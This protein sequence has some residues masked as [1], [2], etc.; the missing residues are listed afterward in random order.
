MT[1][2]SQSCTQPSEK[3]V[4]VLDFIAPPLL[5][6]SEHGVNGRHRSIRQNYL[7]KAP[8]DFW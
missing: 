2:E 4:G 5:D 3:F 1:E 6:A 8:I 7:G